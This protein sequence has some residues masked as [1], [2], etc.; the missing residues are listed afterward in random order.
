MTDMIEKTFRRRLGEPLSGSIV[1]E[2]G[3]TQ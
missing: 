1:H 2:R 3:L